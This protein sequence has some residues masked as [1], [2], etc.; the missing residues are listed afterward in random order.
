MCKV[1]KVSRDAYYPWKKR[2]GGPAP[3]SGAAGPMAKIRAVHAQSRQ[4]YGG[5]R[6]AAEP[7]RQGV[8]VSRSYVARLMK[9]MGLK[10]ALAK[11]FVAT[12]DSKHGNR[13]APNKL[14]RDFN[15]QGTGKVWVPDI[16]YIR[17]ADS[18]AHLTTMID[19]ADRK[20]V[21][22]SLSRGMTAED[23]VIRAW[24]AARSKRGTKKG[25][26]PHSDRGVQYACGRTRELFGMNKRAAQSMSRKGDCWDNAVAESFFKTIKYERPDRVKFSSFDQLYAEIDD[27]INWYD[28]KRLHSTLGYKTPLEM[29]IELKSK[30]KRAA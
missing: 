24:S 14:K 9:R 11:K 27:Y 30:F 26:V 3:K 2:R 10:S 1:L 13:V 8:K 20:V 22:W 7:G 17:V 4:T 12:T 16:T 19:L 21:G 28:T 23:T 6:V 5:H 18:W 29:E 25:F 15:V